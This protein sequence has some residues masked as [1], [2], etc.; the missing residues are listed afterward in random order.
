[1]FVIT[2]ASNALSIMTAPCNLF[3]NLEG[4][5]NALTKSYLLLYASRYAIYRST[6]DVS[7]VPAED[8]LGALIKPGRWRSFRLGFFILTPVLCQI[9]P[10]E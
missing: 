8:M 2:W 6:L 3:I 5:I 9:S 10:I 1:M 4:V 7:I